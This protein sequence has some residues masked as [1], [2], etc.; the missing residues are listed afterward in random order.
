[1]VNHLPRPKYETK[2]TLFLGKNVKFCRGKPQELVGNSKIVIDI[3]LGEWCFTSSRTITG[4]PEVSKY[5]PEVVL[6]SAWYR[7]CHGEELQM[8]GR[9][10][11]KQWKFPLECCFCMTAHIT[12][13]IGGYTSPRNSLAT[14]RFD[15]IS[16]RLLYPRRGTRNV[17]PRNN[18]FWRENTK[19]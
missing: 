17:S 19:K 16:P 7:Q 5:L 6:P 11:K 4:L 15:M 10:S 14:L 18:D 9:E 12:M 8:R 13:V 3:N 1:M 2:I